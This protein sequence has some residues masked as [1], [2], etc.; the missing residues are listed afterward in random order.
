MGVIDVL[1]I[2]SEFQNKKLRMGLKV[3]K[4]GDTQKLENFGDALQD[5]SS[6]HAW[7]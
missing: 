5:V 6:I 3:N 1:N 2:F 7:T 4:C